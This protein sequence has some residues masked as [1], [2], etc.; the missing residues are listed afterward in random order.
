MTEAMTSAAPVAAPKKTKKKLP[1]GLIVGLVMMGILILIALIGPIFVTKDAN[2][3][4]DNLALEPSGEHWLG[5][6]DFGQDNFSRIIVG[7]RLTLFMTIA[8]AAIS[9]IVGL[10][11]GI[12]IWL[13]PRRVREWSL[14]VLET[15]VAYP[16]LITA[17]VIAAILLPSA[18]TAVVA[19]GIAGIP[20]FARVTANL[21]QQVSNSEYF[22]A[23]KYLGV[24][25]F[26][27]ATRHMIPAMSEP[28]LV[29]ATT[30]FAATLVEIS[31]LSFVGLGVQAP[32]YDL[33]ALLNDSLE[34]L[35]TNPI[36]AVGP[37]V[38]IVLAS[39]AAMLIGDGLAA[40]ANPRSTSRWLFGKKR[41]G[42]TGPADA[43]VSVRD[44]TVSR[45]SEDGLVPLVQGISL[46]IGPGE[47]LGIVGESGSG[48]SVTAMTV[49]G[50][51]PRELQ[52]DAAEVRV[53][54][55]DMQGNAPRGEL[56]KQIGIIYQDPATTF[57]PAL[58]M[59]SQ[60]TEVL[61]QHVGQSKSQARKTVAERLR[62]IGIGNPEQRMHQF[63]HEL[64]G[65]LRQRALIGSALT[66]EPKLLIAD[67]PTTALDVTVQK[68]VL[69][70]FV[71]LR[72]EYGTSVLFISH[73]IG[74]VEEL[75]DR[76]LVMEKG[77]IVEEMTPQQLR[78][79]DVKHPYT[80]KLLDA[81]PTLTV[82]TQNTE[83]VR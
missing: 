44:L 71:R 48:K 7:L 2:T 54:G 82:G 5:T 6:N 45:Q 27:L 39:V 43:I 51:L 47:I 3:L 33:G 62:E 67:E 31:A 73:D 13:A 29:L 14:R 30:I 9:V 15:A 17:L 16:T 66:T 63:P 1:T 40:R 68:D 75:C 50:L 37:V 78:E 80:K 18:P 57:S 22:T 79:R 21:A 24:S 12:G 38:G 8:A 61:T 42:A 77:A 23:A 65:G 10:A 35:Y 36:E 52:V 32:T 49:A 60:L 64:S 53:G 4:T 74:V 72:H 46:D 76:V 69:K 11:I 28:L 20:G 26:K 83:D 19:M 55:L 81:V 41:K 70:Q 56:A 25:P 59:G 58:R 34:S